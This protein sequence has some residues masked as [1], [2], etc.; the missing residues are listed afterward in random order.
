MITVRPGHRTGLV[1]MPTSLR[2]L[3]L[4]T[5]WLLFLVGC[6]SAGDTQSQILTL[7]T[8]TTPIEEMSPSD[9]LVEPTT[10]KTDSTPTAVE[11]HPEATITPLPSPSPTP[12]PVIRQ[13]TTGR[14]CVE[15]FWSPDGNQV[16]FIDR[17][18]QEAPSGIWGIDSQGG[19]PRF[20]TDQLGIFSADMQLRAY[21]ENRGTFVQNLLT[22]ET[23]RIPNGGRAVSF[24]PDN[25]WLAWT[26]GQRGPPFDTAQRE[27][28]ISRVDGSEGQQV[29]MGTRAGFEGWLPDGRMLVTGLVGDESR[30]QAL[31]ILTP[32]GGDNLVELAR[33]NRLRT[34]LISPGGEWV[35][36]L[37]TFSPDPAQDGLWLVSTSTGEQRRLDV[38]GSYQWQDEG[39][40][41]VIPLD[42]DQPLN[43][44]LQ[45]EAAT[46]Q[47]RALTDPGI[48]PFKI[49]NGDWRVSP[50]G[51][52]IIF[53]S[54]EDGNIW[55]IELPD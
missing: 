20:I 48:P 5:I 30:N 22:G 14:C 34:I 40:L 42:L 12:L 18:A 26:A 43:Q 6:S 21:L 3:L 38:F 9:T 23:W 41:L 36:Y 54:A 16:L 49:A 51:S 55:L 15:P 37:V 32:G 44:L 11:A 33:G 10:A 1:R 13:L 29:F 53:V 25:A 19:E 35:A 27:V 47:V 24:A 7:P 39:H 50:G 52:E 28:W 2:F 46:G 45:V 31:W 8:T 4:P 17:P